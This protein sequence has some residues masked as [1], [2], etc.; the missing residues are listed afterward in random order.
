MVDWVR[1][2]WEA[3][4]D[5]DIANNEGG[6]PTGFAERIYDDEILDLLRLHKERM[7]P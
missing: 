3:G 7:Q 5:I 6:T 4:D 1:S 2:R